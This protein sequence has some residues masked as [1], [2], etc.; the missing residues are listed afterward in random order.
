MQKSQLSEIVIDVKD[1]PSLPSVVMKVNSAL[2]DKSETTHGICKIIEKDFAL[3]S[4]IL[5]LANSSYYGLSYSVDT[6]SMAISILGFNTVRNLAVTVSLHNIFDRSSSSFDAK[7][8]WF[9]SLGTAIASKALTFKGKNNTLKEKAFICGMLHDIG[10]LVIN[11]NLPEETDRIVER[12]K[13][14]S[15]LTLCK[16]EME[17]L[18]FTHPEAGA[19]VAEKWHFPHELI[20]A[21]KFHHNPEMTQKNRKLIYAV[22][23]GNEIA[24][25]LNLGK[26]ISDKIADINPVTWK[27]LSLSEKDLSL[28][29]PKIE[30]DFDDVIN[31]MDI[32]IVN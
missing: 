29:I 1:I 20:N 25:A 4:K 3:T 10:N 11:K 15:T 19:L 27:E 24:K 9:H 2:M 7:G 31:F 23:A 30:T 18:G 17:V 16:A 6:L 26:S 12:L 21:I 5:K 32:R 8:L 13:G 14:D 28:L 22:Y